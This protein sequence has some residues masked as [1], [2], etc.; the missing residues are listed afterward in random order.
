MQGKP[1]VPQGVLGF[2]ITIDNKAQVQRRTWRHRFNGIRK[3]S[4]QRRKMIH[5]GH[6]DFGNSGMHVT[7]DIGD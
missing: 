5:T 3:L 6:V 7:Q 4:M 2:N 1:Q